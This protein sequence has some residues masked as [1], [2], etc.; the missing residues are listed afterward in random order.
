MNTLSMLRR[1][2]F[3]LLALVPLCLAQS[4]SAATADAFVDINPIS[5]LWWNPNESGWGVSVVQEFDVAFVTMFVYD[6]SGN[7]IWY[8]A[9]NCVTTGMGC[10]GTLYRTAGG[11]SPTVP[12]VGPITAIAV[13]SV[14]LSF[15][16][17]DT[18]TLSY[19]ING[20]SASKPIVRQ[21]WRDGPP[22]PTIVPYRWR[23]DPPPPT[24][25]PYGRSGDR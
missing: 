4:A 7:P 9:S 14:T 19:T 3:T 10:S 18:G 20:V 5:G 1:W 21:I 12:W 15:S 25:V 24:I 2:V 8:V 6:A 16:D 22:P 11:Q 17:L 13:G 23:G